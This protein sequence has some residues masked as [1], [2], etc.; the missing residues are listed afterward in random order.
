[1]GETMSM[2]DKSI[3]ITDWTGRIL[4]ID[5]YDS[6]EVD[7]VLDANRCDCSD[8]DREACKKCDGT[9][10]A[11]DIEVEWIDGDNG[12]LNVYEYINY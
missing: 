7:A 5:D 4:L 8:E 2:K 6:P 9:G 3:K 11:G 12:D 10:Y 1:M